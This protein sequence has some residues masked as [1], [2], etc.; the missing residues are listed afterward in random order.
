MSKWRMITGL[1]FSAVVLTAYLG[2]GGG[3]VSSGATGS[4]RITVM[5]PSDTSELAPQRLPYATESVR[6]TIGPS[7]ALVATAQVP[8]W[9]EQVLLQKPPGGGQVSATTGSVP[10]GWV[11]VLAQAFANLQGTGD[12]IA[13]AQTE[14]D[15]PAGGTATAYLVTEALT[16]VVELNVSTLDLELTQSGILI[17]TAKDA[18]GAVIIG[19]DFVW[20]SND[21]AVA[22]VAALSP[23][24]TVTSVADGNC[25]VTA[26]ETI[27]GKS[28]QCSVTVA[29]RSVHTV[30]LIPPDCILYVFDGPT[31][32]QLT[33]TAYDDL[34]VFIP[35]VEFAWESDNPA[36]AT[37]DSTGLVTATG[38]G[39]CQVT[40]TGSTAAGSAQAT[41]QVTVWER[42]APV[43]ISLAGYDITYLGSQYDSGNNET[44]FCYLV[45]GT[46]VWPTFSYWVIGLP[47]CVTRDDVV[48]YQ[49]V[50]GCSFA[51]PDSTTGVRGLKH[52]SALSPNESR[53]Y[54]FTL[55]GYYE[56]GTVAVAV[57][58][59]WSSEVGEIDGPACSLG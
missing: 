10:A 7:E 59:G 14:V 45:A 8:G 54:C 18:D 29:S 15:V 56:E 6:V 13:L 27:T 24:A 28:A 21:Q 39:L 47:S 12:V 16:V 26:T 32:Q 49:P 42:Y 36:V 58:A 51:D 34:G 2:C 5:F 52:A 38:Q 53:V 20:D 11:N 3:G 31:E 57:K 19:A 46:G 30:E 4:V 25:E 55:Q 22:T 40:V 43:S 44:S 17:A 9:Q 41:C 50:E 48:A 35:Y 1:L 33:A 23:S 37:V